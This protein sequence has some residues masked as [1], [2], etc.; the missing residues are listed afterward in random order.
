MTNPNLGRPQLSPELIEVF[1]AYYRQ[2]PVWGSL[3]LVM[4]DGNYG[5]EH[6]K[7]C[8]KWATRVGDKD[9]LALGIILKGM[10]RSQRFHIAKRARKLVDD[11]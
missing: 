1:A 4:E 8:I 9:G 2:N 10:T 11:A 5:D 6:V 7:C 3:H